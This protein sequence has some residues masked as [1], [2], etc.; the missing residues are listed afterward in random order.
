MTETTSLPPGP[1]ARW[2]RLVRRRDDK[3]VAGVCAAAARLTG[4]DPVLWRVVLAVLTVF[5]G[6]GLVL[7]AAGWL[8]IPEEG[9]P[10]STGERLLR[11]RGGDLSRPS[12]LVLIALAAVAVA[13]VVG[14]GIGLAPLLVVGVVVWL[15]RRSRK[16]SPTPTPPAP[17]DPSTWTVPPT[18]GSP[19]APPR[20]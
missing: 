9:Q 4:T 7:Y 19:Y 12:T 5:G 17:V 18:P 11:T 8:L 14:D 15:V 16:E 10:E 20:S 1:S 2:P 13:A 6:T 3:V